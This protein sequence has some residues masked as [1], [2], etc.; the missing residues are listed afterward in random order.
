MS[1]TFIRRVVS[2][3]RNITTSA[4]AIRCVPTKSRLTFRISPIQNRNFNDSKAP[5]KQTKPPKLKNKMSEKIFIDEAEKLD[6]FKVAEAS[7]W[8]KIT[9]R[10]GISKRFQF[11]NFV[12]AFS[13]MT[14]VALEAEKMDHHPEWSNVY[15]RVDICLTSHFCNGFSRLDSKLA[16]IIDSLFIKYSN[17]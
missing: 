8:A 10:E 17:K 1:N 4:S 2:G 6:A 3:G 16:K 9:P 7:G 5:D 13:F 14:A 15:N 12:E 11:Q